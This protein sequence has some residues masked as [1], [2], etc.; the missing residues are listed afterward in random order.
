[1]E[2]YASGGNME[3]TNI[4]PTKNINVGPYER[5]LSA[6]GGAALLA[7]SVIRPSRLS[8]PLAASGSYLVFRGISGRCLAYKVMNI[9]R[10]ST[11]GKRGIVVER[12]VTIN[13][14]REEV[15]SFWRDFENLPRFM[16]HL[17]SVQVSGDK[18]TSRTSHWVAK[19]PLDKSV[20]WEAEIIEERPNEYIY[21]KSLP[22]SLIK[23]SG[24][25]GFRD[26]PGG[27]GTE[28]H[29]SFTYDLPGGSASAAFAK[30]L[31]EEPGSQVREDLR[32]FKQMLE[33]GETATV[34]G[35]PSGRRKQV[36]KER[37]EIDQQK[38]KDVVQEA[39]EESFPASDAPGWTSRKD[40]PE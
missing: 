25:V 7:V 29:V 10:I 40:R 13:R 5:A 23:T 20:Q 11:N 31:G 27:R 9:N 4:H 8:L 34:I 32:R 35:Q 15:Y 33:A 39:S 26:A 17:N 12:S 28:V 38:V 22:G 18:L 6:L 30:L 36:E 16:A 19:A 2:F 21:W 24:S 14:P 3:H 37:W 1:M